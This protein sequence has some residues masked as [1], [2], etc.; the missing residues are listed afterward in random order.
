MFVTSSFLL[1]PEVAPALSLSEG[2]ELVDRA[3][4]DGAVNYVVR[5]QEKSG[6]FPVI[7]RLHNYY[8]LVHVYTHTHTHTHTHVF[9]RLSLT[10]LNSRLA[11]SYSIMYMYVTVEHLYSGYTCTCTTRSICI[12][13]LFSVVPRF[14]GL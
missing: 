1:L 9:N 10:V 2:S 12:E 6:R 3:V 8:L 5:Q 7:G 13:D 11:I 14:Q 4:I